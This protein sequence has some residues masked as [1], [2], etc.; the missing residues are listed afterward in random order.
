MDHST[1]VVGDKIITANQYAVSRRPVAKGKFIYLGDDKLYVRGVTYGPFCPDVNGCEYKNPQ[2]LESDFFQMRNNN[3]NTIRTYT[4]PPRWFLDLAFKHGLH[5]MVG[6]LGTHHSAFLDDRELV[7]KIRKGVRD[8]LQ[9][10]YDHPAIL[11]YSI[12]NEIPASIVRWYGR[13]RVENYLEDMYKFVKD[14][15]PGSLVTY[16][17]Y[18][19]TEYLQ[20]P[21]FDLVCFNV[22][23]ESESALSKYI[24]RLQ[25]I[26]GDKPLIL[27]EIGLD[28]RRN[29]IHEQAKSLSSQIKNTFISGCAGAIVF[30]WTDEWHRGG[31]DIDDWDFGITTRDRNPKPALEKVRNAYSEVPFKLDSDWPGIS[32]IICTY[33]GSKT[34][35]ECLE[36]ISKLDYPNYEVV[37]VND[38]SSDNTIE[39]IKEYVNRHGFKSTTTENLGLSNARNIGM[40]LASNDIVAYIDDDAYPDAQWLKYIAYDFMRTNYVGTGGPNVTPDS[41]GF[42]ARCISKSPGNPVQVLISDREAEHLPGCNMA[43][44]KSILQKIGGFDTKFKI[45]GDDV[46]LCWRLLENGYKLGYNPSAMVWHRRRNSIRKYLKQQYNYGRAESLLEKKWPEKFSSEGNVNWIGK[47]YGAGYTGRKKSFGSRIYHGTWGTAPFQSLYQ[48]E[49]GKLSSYIL[50][51]EWYL[52]IICLV[53]F[54]VLGLI[55]KP[56]LFTLPLLGFAISMLVIIAIRNAN[57]ASKELY[58][59]SFLE[60]VKFITIT[61]LLHLLQPIA[62]LQGRIK[63][64]L[65]PWRRINYGFSLPWP[66]LQSFWSENWVSPE[67]RLILVENSIKDKGL[68]VRRGGNFDSW[69]LEIRGGLFGSTRLIMV[70]EEHERGRQMTRFKSWPHISYIVYIVFS[71]FLGLAILAGIDHSWV[72]F[73]FLAIVTI[74]ITYRAIGDC[75]TSNFITIEALKSQEVGDN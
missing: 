32:V 17:N 73:I 47:M 55:W 68:V 40:N 21:F 67:K 61:S 54:S 8:G 66:K 7:S 11:C 30:A 49:Y 24:A 71:I 25:T 38:G 29:G 65:T 74:L 5:V 16:V 44:R 37:V 23:L 31:Q 20:L 6:L 36:Y 64:G 14:K 34:L 43:F 1:I 35:H 45:A 41:D 70:S 51:P 13:K 15:D 75:A 53:F 58:L 27:A 69:D 26:S 4:V 62:R 12:G 46:D 48:N 39:I 3:I 19:T 63:E 60:K 72:A 56:L 10:C 57:H 33:N 28:S 52:V 22:Y 9:N 59:S 18:P 2:I 50:M 42:K